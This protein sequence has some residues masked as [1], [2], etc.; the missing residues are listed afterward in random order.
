M[1][2]ISNPINS[3]AN[4]YAVLGAD[5]KVVA[6]QLPEMDYVSPSDIGRTTSVSSDDSNYSTYMT[7]GEA[8]FASDTTPSAN[9]QIAWTYS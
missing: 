4:D 7:R 6:S 1:I 8:L 5:G 9:G 3:K 2:V